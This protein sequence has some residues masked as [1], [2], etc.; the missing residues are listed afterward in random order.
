MK[1]AIIYITSA[2]LLTC[3]SC[4]KG[5][6][7]VT[8]IDNLSGNNYWKSEADVDQFVVGIYSKFREATMTKIFFP[9]TGDLRNAPTQR[10]SATSG[11]ERNYI[12]HLRVNNLNATLHGDFAYFNFEGISDWGSFYNMVQLSNIVLFEIDKLDNGI[13][14]EEK[15][16][17]YKAEAVFLRNI[18][19]FFMVRLFGDVPYYTEAYHSKAIGRT[20]M[21]TVLENSYQDVLGSYKNL[22]WTYE[23]PSIV[24]N[25]AMRGAAITLMMHMNMWLA[26]FSEENKSMYY[27]RVEALGKEVME[28][29]E[30]SYEL[31]ALNRTKEIFKGRTREG[32]FEIVQNLNYGETFSLTAT[33][34]DY[35]LRF[36]NKRNLVSYIFYDSKFME[37]LYPE[38]GQD[39]RKTVWFDQ[40]INNSSGQMQMLK[41]VNVFMEEG[42]DFNPDDNQIVFR[43][44][45]PILLRAEALAELGRDAEAREVVN[46]VRQRAN[47][48]LAV[49]QSGEE[50]KDF[51]WWERTRELM[52]EGHFFYDLVRTKKVI[53]SSYTMAPMSVD[54][55]NKGGWT[56]PIHKKALVNNPFMTLNNYW[57]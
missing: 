23:D 41:F 18:A 43:Y 7:N 32:L 53:N 47:A 55:F 24:G 51:I 34:A 36:P 25:R 22:P 27:E 13:L 21:L 4:G 10:T 50:L 30:N 12:S 5:F 28:Q 20:N 57:N 45:D 39:Q 14:T 31:L 35:V 11:A 6:L 46:I 26:G 33:Y 49:S 8:P 54:A 52:G 2:L 42:E 1:R 37:K 19:Y 16:L 3:S 48:D 56:W 17:K 15:K 40:Y 29:N 38:E 44:A 9:A